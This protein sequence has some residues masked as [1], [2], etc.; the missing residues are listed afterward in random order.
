MEGLTK[1]IAENPVVTTWITVISLV[2]V[3]FTITA[4]ILQI[5]DKKKKA[6]YYTIVST[7]LVDNE[8]SQLERIKILFDNEEVGTVV[9]SN[10]KL[11][12]GGNEILEKTDFYPEHELKL[13][14]P[15]SE[16]ILGAKMAEE[17]DD[18]CKINIQ[19]SET[20]V[21][22]ALI[23]F[24][25]LEPHQGA[26]INVYHTNINSEETEIKGK[27]KGGK[28]I[29]K[30]MEITVEN[31]EMCMSNGKYKIYF[32]GGVFRKST[33]IIKMIESFGFFTINTKKRK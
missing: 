15:V 21:N 23:S 7:V 33:Q 27:I 24:Y 18:V 19:I 16:R 1:W 31:G 3:V 14:V 26:I 8:V 11:W 29:N 32:G 2:G 28:I 5:R 13:V 30:S 20:K 4:L 22:E 6:I 17:T 12:N 9:I 10:I 25:C